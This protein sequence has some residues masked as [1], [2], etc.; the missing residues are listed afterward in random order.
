MDGGVDGKIIIPGSATTGVTAKVK[1]PNL[2]DQ[3]SID[4]GMIDIDQNKKYGMGLDVQ[5][6]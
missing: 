5:G 6:A 1:L 2:S 3:Y 4:K